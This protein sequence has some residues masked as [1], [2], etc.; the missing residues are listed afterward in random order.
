MCEKG[1][2][3]LQSPIYR[4][5]ML[6]FRAARKM[7]RGGGDQAGG[8]AVSWRRGNVYFN[9]AAALLHCLLGGSHLLRSQ[10]QAEIL[11]E[12]PLVCGL[13][14]GTA[15]ELVMSLVVPAAF[16]VGRNGAIHLS[17]PSF[18]VFSAP[19]PHVGLLRPSTGGPS[20]R[21]QDGRLQ[22]SNPGWTGGLSPMTD[23]LEA[24][25][26]LKTRL[27]FAPA[28]KLASSANRRL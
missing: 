27:K 19:G 2:G 24:A 13:F 22:T 25:K 28:Y 3:G 9:C 5:S 21:S 11:T 14:F 1:C 17:R 16:R 8:A 23:R 7:V 18:R 12:H 15:V 10:P 26:P 4:A 6:R 20:L